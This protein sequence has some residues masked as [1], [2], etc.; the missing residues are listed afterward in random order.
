[1][2]DIYLYYEYVY[3]TN[4]TTPFGCRYWRVCTIKELTVYFYDIDKFIFNEI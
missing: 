2:F 1:M 3:S 4:E